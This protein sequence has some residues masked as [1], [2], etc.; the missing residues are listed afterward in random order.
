MS[1]KLFCRN[2][3]II[4]SFILFL[5]LNN[6]VTTDKTL[7]L[8]ITASFK[9]QNG[10]MYLGTFPVIENSLSIFN[11]SIQTESRYSLTTLTERSK[12][13]TFSKSTK[14]VP[15]TPIS[16]LTLTSSSATSIFNKPTSTTHN[17][18]VYLT[19]QLSIAQTTETLSLTSSILSEPIFTTATSS[20]ERSITLNATPISLSTPKPTT[21]SFDASLSPDSSSTALTSTTS[22][23][24]VSK[25]KP[26]SSIEP[27]A[28]T[29]KSTTP[30][31]KLYL[32]TLPTPSYSS[33]FQR[34]MS[35]QQP[36]RH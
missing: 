27:T 13:P 29:Q 7:E 18:T 9:S 1:K 36:H 21:L 4:V 2:G 20:Q 16:Y 30:N 14:S 12:T 19:A 24:D 10:R 33:S 31:Q 32:S 22:S 6:K 8:A 17:S 11:I 35:N 5:E 34:T 28:T 15:I 25:T 26:P 3:S 23:V